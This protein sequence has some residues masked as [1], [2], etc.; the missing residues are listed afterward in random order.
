MLKNIV[1]YEKISPLSINVK[2]RHF[3]ILHRIRS[4]PGLKHQ[5]SNA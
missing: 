3:Q 2:S 4:T 5:M 1:T